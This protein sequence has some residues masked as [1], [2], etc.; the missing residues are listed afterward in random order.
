LPRKKP[1][2]SDVVLRRLTDGGLHALARVAVDHLLERPVSDLVDAPWAAHQMVLALEAV[3]AGPETEAWLGQRIAE[4]REHVPEGTAGDRVPEEIRRPLRDVVARPYLPDRVL[5]G[6]LLDHAAMQ[7]LLRDVLVGALQSF[8]SK[9]KAPVPARL[10][11]LRALGGKALQEGLLGG[12]SQEIERHA[13]ARIRDFVDGAVHTFVAQVADHVTAP[14]HAARYAEFRAHV[15]DTL[16]DTELAVFAGEIDKLHPDDLVSTGAA[17]ARALARRAG[18]EGEI[19]AAIRAAVEASGEQS[20]GQ[21]L[22]RAGVREG[23]RSEAEAQLVEQ[24]E[25]VVESPPF[26]RWLQDLL[27]PE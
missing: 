3:S 19:T 25:K 9:L 4:L 6:R 18:F 14:E 1:Q 24:I 20:L 17:T 11:R 26:R 7:R 13:E 10:S 16:L 21:L 23:W 27:A 8:V 22:A 15:L 12:L 5:V 2:Q